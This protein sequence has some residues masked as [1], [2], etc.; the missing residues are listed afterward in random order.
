MTT[1]NTCR[2]LLRCGSRRRWNNGRG[3]RRRT[4]LL[5]ALPVALLLAVGLG[6]AGT[7]SAYTHSW[8]C[9]RHSGNHC[10]DTSGQ[11]YNPWH[12]LSGQATDVYGA[13]QWCVKGTTSGGT[14]YEF[15]CFLSAP[16]AY[17]TRC[18]SAQTQAYTY[19]I[20]TPDSDRPM[21]AGA[22]TTGGC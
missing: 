5:G 19:G 10:T 12:Y 3:S 9:T 16:Y 2:G 17:G 13:S 4:F 1:T 15:A 8:S 20:W 14:T 21:S 11:A 7:A 6:S 18:I 22:N